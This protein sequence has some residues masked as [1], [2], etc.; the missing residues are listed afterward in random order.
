MCSAIKEILKILALRSF[1]VIFFLY[2][3]CNHYIA[4]DT[5]FFKAIVGVF[6][7]SLW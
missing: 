1:L 3:K 5:K 4:F 7:L 2:K 6:G